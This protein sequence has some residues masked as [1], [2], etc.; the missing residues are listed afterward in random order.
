[1]YNNN[2][3][4]SS[5]NNFTIDSFSI[6]LEYNNSYPTYLLKIYDAETGKEVV[7]GNGTET[8]NNRKLFNIT[9]TGADNHSSF[10][11]GATT[12]IEINKLL[13]ARETKSYYFVYVPIYKD[14]S[15]L[16]YCLPWLEKGFTTDPTELEFVDLQT[17]IDYEYKSILTV[18]GIVRY[19]NQGGES[20]GTEAF[21]DEDL[22][23]LAYEK[24]YNTTYTDQYILT[25]TLG[26]KID[27]IDFSSDNGKYKLVLKS[28]ST[29]GEI[30]SLRGIDLLTG[31]VELDFEGTSLLTSGTTDLNITEIE[32]ISKITNLQ[33]LNL[34]T[35]NIYDSKQGTVGFADGASNDILLILSNLT[36]LKELHLANNKIYSFADLD[37]FASLEYVDVA[38]NTFRSPLFA[39]NDY[40]FLRQINVTL[41]NIIN[42]INGSN[43]AL[44]TSVFTSLK[45]KGV[46]VE[47]AA[48]VFITDSNV[49]AIINALVSL[50]YQDKLS[51]ELPINLIYKDFSVEGSYYNLLD[52]FDAST[53]T[54][55]DFEF[56]RIE[57]T[58]NDILNSETGEYQGTYF[59]FNIVYDCVYKLFGFEQSE[60]IVYSQNYRVTRY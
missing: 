28:G 59:T 2:F 24:L 47:G 33:I 7:Y 48:E 37:L 50:E 53:G 40:D 44:N 32:Y 29:A 14:N 35:T 36:N 54:R 4:R 20:I 22:Y 30:D 58:A 34:N 26:R 11:R 41:T 57:F 39:D 17:I 49:L 43:G 55:V 21:A 10:Q 38:N 19:Q 12:N 23:A 13:I 18:P 6:P 9:L 15:T 8:G 1:M 25:S 27:L 31:I 45:S 51:K 5:N 52:Y 56:N 3:I 16:V 60:T 42:S 46:I